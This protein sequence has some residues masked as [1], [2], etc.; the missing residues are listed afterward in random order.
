L[1]IFKIDNRVELNKFVNE[2][3]F[4]FSLFILDKFY[5]EK[6]YMLIYVVF[7]Y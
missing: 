7:N 2:Y 5:I 3:C 4:Y 6:I 1:I